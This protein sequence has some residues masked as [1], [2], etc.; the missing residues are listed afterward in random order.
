MDVGT[1]MIK[2][3]VSVLFCMGR[4][5]SQPWTFFT[6]TSQNVTH[7]VVIKVTLVT[8][9]FVIPGGSAPTWES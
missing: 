1:Q 6:G 5:M 9:A 3:W 8:K 7:S 2:I 4:H